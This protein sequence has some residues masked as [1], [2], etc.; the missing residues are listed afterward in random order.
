MQHMH[1]VHEF[2]LE[3][4]VP[5]TVDRKKI[6]IPVLTEPGQGIQVDFSGKLHIEHVTGEPYFLIAIDRYIKWPI[7]QTCKS[8][9]TIEVKKSLES[10]INLQGVP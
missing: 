7:V 3:F 8:T 10:S 6:K 5:V 1:C 2:W 4:K 9:K